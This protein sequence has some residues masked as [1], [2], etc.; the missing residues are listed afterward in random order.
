MVENHVVNNDNNFKLP[1]SAS[2]YVKLKSQDHIISRFY[3]THVRKPAQKVVE[4][5]IN[6]NIIPEIN[7]MFTPMPNI[8][9][10]FKD[11]MKRPN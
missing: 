10:S 8:P 6:N 5:A 9:Q 3:L 7:N 2:G 4:N 1:E 11:V